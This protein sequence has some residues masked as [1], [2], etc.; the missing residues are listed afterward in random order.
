MKSN[1]LRKLEQKSKKRS[2]EQF[3]AKKNSKRKRSF[4]RLKN[5]G[6][7][8]NAKL[9]RKSKISKFREIDRQRKNYCSN[10]NNNKMQKNFYSKKQGVPILQKNIFKSIKNKSNF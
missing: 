8:F 3:N 10:K 4:R 6:S 9:R 5:T 1:L 7:G 2:K